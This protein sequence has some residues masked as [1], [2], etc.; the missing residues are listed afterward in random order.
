MPDAPAFRANDIAAAVE[1]Y[2]SE[3]PN[4]A[5][6]VDGVARWWLPPPLR[7][8]PREQVEAALEMLCARGRLRRRVRGGTVIYGRAHGTDDGGGA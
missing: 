1:A 2:L 4:A 8:A 7:G 3:R 6:S 5:D